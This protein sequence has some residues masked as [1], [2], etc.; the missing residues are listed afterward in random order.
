MNDLS[1][2]ELEYEIVESKKFVDNIAGESNIFCYPYGGVTVVTHDTEKVLYDSGFRYAL[3]TAGYV[4]HRGTDRYRVGRISILDSI[5]VNKL[6]F[7]MSRFYHKL[8]YI[9]DHLTGNRFYNQVSIAGR[10]GIN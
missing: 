1:I 10:I 3:T 4:L 5:S 2:S 9:R 7:Y 6:R 8:R